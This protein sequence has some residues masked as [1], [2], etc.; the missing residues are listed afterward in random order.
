MRASAKQPTELEVL[1]SISTK[2]DQILTLL[3]MKGSSQDEA[4][5][6]LHTFNNDWQTVAKLTGL[7]PDAARMRFDRMSRN[8]TA[9]KGKKH[10]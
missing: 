9:R 2:L 3:I 7:T 5:R 6:V 8:G 10:E 4:I 1:Q